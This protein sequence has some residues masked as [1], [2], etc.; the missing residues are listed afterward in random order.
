M[1][2]FP[3]QKGTGSYLKKE[4]A[5]KM[6]KEAMAKMKKEAMAKMKEE[7]GMMMK[8]ESMAKMKEAMKMK[9][10]SMAKQAKP[11]FPDID[12]DGNTKE[13]M[14]KAAADKKSPTKQKYDKSDTDERVYDLDQKK[15]DK[16][17]STQGKKFPDI[18][19]LGK[20]ENKK[21]LEEYLKSKSISRSDKNSPAPQKENPAITKYNKAVKDAKDEYKSFIGKLH[22]EGRADTTG[23]SKT[24]GV[25]NLTKVD[26]KAVEKAQK[27]AAKKMKAAEKQ[28]KKDGLTFSKQ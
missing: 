14:K 11:D 19:Y 8:K 9:K 10:E 5:A 12:G 16:F 21:F 1:K 25:K 2:G 6:K 26:K 27:E 18:R 22:S 13:S 15:Y 20:K 17:R 7:E 24:G 3:M 28:A 23:Y 4:S